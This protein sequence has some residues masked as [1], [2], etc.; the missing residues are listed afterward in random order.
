MPF[1]YEIP[2]LSGVVGISAGYTHSLAVLKD[3]T[4]R[5]WGE[6]ISGEVGDGTTAVRHAPVVVPGIKDAVGVAAGQGI[7][8]ALLGDGTVM[9]WGNRF[10]GALG[11]TPDNAN[12]ADGVPA[13]VP[14]VKGVRTIVSGYAH[15]LAITE[16]GTLVSWG[17][18]NFGRLGRTGAYTA[19]VIPG[20]SGVQSVAVHED[21]S[22]AV[23][24]SG[25]IMTWGADVRPWTRPP[26]EGSYANISHRPI[27]LWLD[28]L[29]QP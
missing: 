6:N 13:L 24:A 14:G 10:G 12:R 21:T 26:E 4:V 7:S 18:Q 29:E 16:A 2:G 23:L 9:S 28:G 15:V 8:A 20:L 11:R 3:G 5:A 27:L 25:R 1:P 22:I 17:N 19:A